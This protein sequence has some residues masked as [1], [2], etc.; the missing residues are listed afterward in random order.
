MQTKHKGLHLKER[1]TQTVL[2][3]FGIDAN[4][5]ATPNGPLPADA[6]DSVLY[7]SLAQTKPGRRI[8]Q[9]MLAFL[10]ALQD[11]GHSYGDLDDGPIQL[12]HT[13][14]EHCAGGGKAITIV[15]D[16]T[17]STDELC[18]GRAALVQSAFLARAARANMRYTKPEERMPIL[19]INI[20]GK[21]LRQSAMPSH[22]SASQN[23]L[24]IRFESTSKRLNK[25]ERSVGSITIE[26]FHESN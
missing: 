19:H 2:S 24:N 9:P 8:D 11:P 15:S 16:G 4:Q 22:T 1:F 26:Q 14:A 3:R 20:S 23:R 10:L 18:A 17:L 12:A 25:S 21:P 7:L 6:A 5:I 13:I